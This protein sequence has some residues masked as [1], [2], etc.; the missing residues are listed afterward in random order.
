MLE[1]IPNWVGRS[2]GFP[3]ESAVSD[4]GCPRFK[5]RIRR[6]QVGY[7]ARPEVTEVE[8]SVPS[9]RV[10]E[11]AKTLEGDSLVLYEC[12]SG[13]ENVCDIILKW[14][15]DIIIK[16]SPTKSAV[17][18]ARRIPLSLFEVS[19]HG[20]SWS[21]ELTLPISASG[22][23]D[24]EYFIDA[25]LEDIADDACIEFCNTHGLISDLRKCLDQAKDTFLN[26]LSLKAEYDCYPIDEYEEE[27]H[28]TI[29]VEVDSDQDT[30]FREYDKFV[31]WMLDK[32]T[33]DN[34]D[35]FVLTVNRIE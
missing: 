3:N 9:T 27:G 4:T 21:C 1:V 5:P 23:W 32:I 16:W 30:A 34:L 2:Y 25:Q 35:F 22:E 15:P 13:E 20:A 8:D 18:S 17:I 31:G 6:Q 29:R 33:D 14:S 10:R 7:E 12:L 26:R 24:T 28:I 11:L 19:L